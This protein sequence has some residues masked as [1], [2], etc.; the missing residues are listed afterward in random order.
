VVKSF[1]S[2]RCGL[3]E[4]A[5]TQLRGGVNLPTERFFR[6]QACIISEILKKVL[7]KIRD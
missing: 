1:E 5:A 2:G 6:K 4:E 7:V 3:D